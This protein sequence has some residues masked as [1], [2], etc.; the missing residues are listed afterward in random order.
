MKT[1]LLV[2][3][4]LL[5][6]HNSAAV[7]FD[8]SL[9]AGASRDAD[10][11]RFYDNNDMPAGKQEVDIYVNNDWKGR[12]SVIYGQEQDDIRLSWQ[13]AQLLGINTQK[14][15]APAIPQGQVQLI[16]L[17]QGG[18]IETDISTFS[19]N[20]TVPQ[21][22]IQHREPGYVDAKFWDEGIPALLLSYNTTYYN[23]HT[24]TAAKD[25]SDDLYTGLDSGINLL[26]W[27]L[28]DSSTWQKKAGSRGS[29]Q[30]NTR[31]LRRPL[32]P[33]KSNLMAGDFYTPGDLFDSVRTRGVSLASDSQ[34]RPNSQQGFAP[35][36]HG[37]ALTNA[38]VKVIQ[39]G[40]VIYQE[41]VPP[42]S[43]VLD[44]IQPTGSAGD[45][46]IVVQEADGSKQSFL[47]PFSAVPGMLK[48]GV[49][50]FHVVAG[51]IRQDSVENRPGF[52][53]G[54]LRYGINNLITG[55]TGMIISNDY[56]AGLLGSGWNLP[57]GAIS[58][59]VTHADTKLQDRSYSGQS[60]RIAYSKFVD[61]TAT[62]VTLAAYRYSTK[63][64]YSFTSALYAQDGYQNLRRQYDEYE[65]RHGERTD[66]SLEQW[67]ASNDVKPK[68]TFTVN[69]NQRLKEGWGSIYL[70]GT[71][72]DYWNSKSRA[73]E[74]QMGYSNSLGGA[75]YTLSASRVR[76]SDNKEETRLYA[77]ISAPFS[78][79]DNNAWI[80]SSIA[81][82]DSGYEQ[83]N[84][85]LSGNAMESNR[86]SYSIAG[87]NTNGGKNMASVNTTWRSDVSTLGAS[88]SESGD[89]RQAG[90]SSRGSIVAF[91]WHVLAANE[92]G[93]TMTVIEAPGAEG[94]MVNGDESIRTNKEG[95]ALVP[96]ATPYR[97]NSVTLAETTSSSGAEIIGN[98]ANSAPY[99]GAVNYLRF[100]TDRRQ[101]WQVHAVQANGTPLPF[102][103]EVFNEHSEAVG[104]VGQA[105]VIYI[106]AQ[107]M[108]TLLQVHV[109]GGTCTIATPV[110]GLNT[111]PS[112][113]K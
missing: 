67:D 4:T 10:L 89:Y 6:S 101:S 25:D 8:T 16:D 59:D 65:D 57:F 30:N 20:L 73:R 82:T 2:A 56:Q 71:Q 26:G 105:S 3:C 76:N 43:F 64:Y 77:S 70:T 69:M 38:L 66:M 72:R 13:D 28:R 104:Y 91:P 75:N 49:S 41:N 94:L 37:I 54:T 80:S 90:I 9:L 68:N 81:G 99:D 35:V 86:L 5:L 84:I 109:R 108:P 24:K 40:N 14:V 32:A 74:Y 97:K 36:V 17:I 45:L 18:R 88:W 92:I 83:S 60:Y 33:L 51:E 21:A 107:A 100:E 15:P 39:N 110:S 29:W 44:K 106:R 85:S 55:Y 23:S 95:L 34:M 27:Q 58:V 112:L 63:G 96:Y 22:A 47:V 111:A 50:D 78:L 62:N 52:I 19:L 48:A 11:S 7:T 1:K 93:S 53:Q 42:G 79:F 87:N 61:T 113:C 103:T 46:E 12:F 98:M 31:F 102:G